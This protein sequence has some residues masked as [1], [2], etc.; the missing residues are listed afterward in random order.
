MDEQ[1]NDIKTKQ[2]MCNKNQI[3][4]KFVA[5]NAFI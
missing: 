2:P 3:K 4:R 5:L 1:K